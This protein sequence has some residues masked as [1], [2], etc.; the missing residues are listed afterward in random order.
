MPSD[1]DRLRDG[2]KVVIVG[3]GPGGAGCALTLLAMSKKLGIDIDVTIL[4]PKHF[5]FHYN[6]CMGV[7]S[8]PILELLRDEYGIVYPEELIQRCIHGYVLI[9]DNEEIDLPGEI[10]GEVSHAVRRVQFDDIILHHVARQG[11]KIMKARATD[12]EFHREDAIVYS[13]SGAFSA[14]VIVGAF[15]LDRVMVEAFEK[16]SGYRGPD[17]LETIVTKIHPDKR[18]VDAFEDKIYTFL[19]SIPEIEFGAIVPKGNHL[20]VLIAGKKVN[21]KVLKKFLSLERVRELLPFEYSIYDAF[22]GSFPI[23]TA[24][25]YYGDR[26]V[27][28]GDAA[29]LVRPFKGK[30]INSAFITGKLAAETMLE[31]GVSS[32]AFRKFGE[33]CRFISGDLWYGRF[34]RALV[35]LVSNRLS[36]DPLIRKAKG[37]PTLKKALFDAVSGRENYKGILTRDMR[38][39]DYLDLFVTYAGVA[40]RRFFSFRS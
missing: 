26:Y 30:G 13:E 31:D 20:T 6:Q 38:P 8:P 11:A 1:L 40:A 27:I 2:S 25:N 16:R 24:K 14:D 3:G 9:S 7:L 10:A 34:V 22:K 23:T 36:M 32:A 4:E 39:G 19:V 12:I 35:N 28:V 5:G 33:K 37:R 29:G 15:G 21:I 18:F 17:Y